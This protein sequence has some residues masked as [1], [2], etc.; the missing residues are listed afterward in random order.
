VRSWPSGRP[1]GTSDGGA[2]WPLDR[3][4]CK[5]QTVFRFVDGRAMP[6]PP[7]PG[8]SSRRNPRITSNQRGK[9]MFHRTAFAFAI[10]ASAMTSCAFAETDAERQAC[11]A[12]AQ[13]HCGDQIPDRERV[14]AC[15]VQKVAQIRRSST[16]RSPRRDR[17]AG[18]EAR[19]AA[20]L[21]ACGRSF[22]LRPPGGFDC[23]AAIGT[24]GR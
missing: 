17:N 4:P 18:S 23:G 6:G 13:I 9:P 19:P 1:N 10:W 15:L 21:A 22:P 12:D 11:M 2:N 24:G 3:K 16:N 7:T 14:Y 20:P 5:G 8:V